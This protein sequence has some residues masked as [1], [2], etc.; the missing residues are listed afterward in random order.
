MPNGHFSFSGVH[1]PAR[2]SRI[3]PA[4]VAVG[5]GEG[6]S[7]IDMGKCCEAVEAGVHTA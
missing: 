6:L 2:A 1:V 4:G 3:A 7:E 5:G